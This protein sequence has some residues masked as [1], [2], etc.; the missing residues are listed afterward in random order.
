MRMIASGKTVSAI[1]GEL[2]LSAKTISTHRSRIL[3]KMHMKN[4]AELT[5]Y[6]VTKGLVD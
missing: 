3:A 4:S 2:S 6:A 5:H 1:A